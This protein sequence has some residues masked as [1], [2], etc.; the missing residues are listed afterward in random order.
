M[1]QQD[2]G[3]KLKEYGERLG[4]GA[5]PEVTQ[6]YLAEWLIGSEQK[7]GGMHQ[8]VKRRTVSEFDPRSAAQIARGGMTGGDRMSHHGY[9]PIYAQAIAERFMPAVTPEILRELETRFAGGINLKLR[10]VKPSPLDAEPNP[11]SVFDGHRMQA[12]GNPRVHNYA[13]TYAENLPDTDSQ[14]VIVEL[15]ILRGV[16][17]AVWCD[18]FPNAR[19]IGL[20]VD[21]SHF[22]ENEANLRKRGAFQQNSP[23]VFEFDELA[24]DAPER[25]REI[26][27][28]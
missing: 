19:V 11:V 7:Y 5:P 22:S 13:P 23:S 10:P 18:L 2:Q 14:I 17:L 15:G 25:L 12:E 20:D 4:H 6:A 26:H 28:D 21:L 1:Q 27:H 3:E 24:P 16:G 9:A 8:N